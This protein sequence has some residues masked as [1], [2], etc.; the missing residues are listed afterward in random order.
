MRVRTIPDDHDAMIELFLSELSQRVDVRGVI[1]VGAHDGQ[2]VPHYL[3][4]GAR[5]IVLVEANPM[6][7]D[8]LT[9][10]YR[11][12]P[13]ISIVHCAVTDE[14]GEIELNINVSRSGSDEASSVLPLKRLSEIVATLQTKQTLRVPSR[15]L[16]SLAR[17]YDWSECNFLNMDIQGAEFMA[18]R[19]AKA[20]LKQLD[21]ILVE[22][23][24]IE[25][26]AGCA[27]LDDFDAELGRA[28]FT[29]AERVLHEL[30]DERGT[31]PAWGESLYLRT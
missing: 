21:A 31:F 29:C 20:L 15:T 27:T 2:E 16:D 1:H 9:A 28:G 7:V 12:N 22:T 13:D 3:A 5:P 4:R 10:R 19:G 11:S 8:V 23:N 14:D 25:M 30:Y 26:Y 18:L 6:W 24:V 17:Q